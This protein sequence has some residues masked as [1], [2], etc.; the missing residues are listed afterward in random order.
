MSGSSGSFSI[1]GSGLTLKPVS[2]LGALGLG[3]VLTTTISIHDMIPIDSLPLQLCKASHLDHS[4][5]HTVVEEALDEPGSFFLP[6]L[7]LGTRLNS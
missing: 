2:R 6:F 5:C 4:A 7:I 1:G 3:P